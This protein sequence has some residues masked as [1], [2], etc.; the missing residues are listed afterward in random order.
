MFYFIPQGNPSVAV[1]QR[2]QEMSYGFPTKRPAPG[3]VW[4]EATP[5]H[6]T[7]L[8]LTTQYD[9]FEAFMPAVEEVWA[10]TWARLQAGEPEAE[11]E[12]G[13]SRRE[14]CKAVV[15]RWRR[16]DNCDG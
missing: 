1:L 5:E 7:D 8:Q 3:V 12:S 13:V 4:S 2:F 10:A 6:A 11:E 9:A 15:S 14:S 16:G